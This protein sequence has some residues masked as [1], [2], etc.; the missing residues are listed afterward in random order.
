MIGSP[1]MTAAL[2]TGGGAPA[3]Y[4]WTTYNG[5][6]VYWDGSDLY[7]LSGSSLPGGWGRVYDDGSNL[8]V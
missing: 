6:Q 3:G 4:T 2:L 7:V 1:T 8:F 5:Q